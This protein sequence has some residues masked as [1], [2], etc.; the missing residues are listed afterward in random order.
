MDSEFHNE[1]KELQNYSHI[2]NIVLCLN[3]C[4]IVIKILRIIKIAK[5][6]LHFSIYAFGKFFYSKIFVKIYMDKSGFIVP[7]I[8]SFQQ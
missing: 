5:F 7:Y 1:Q 3:E 8:L 6:Y 4:G 2:K